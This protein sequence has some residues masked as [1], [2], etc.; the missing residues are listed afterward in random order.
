[1]FCAPASKGAG[2]GIPLKPVFTLRFPPIGAATK[3]VRANGSTPIWNTGGGGGVRV[4]GN[5]PKISRLLDVVA[6]VVLVAIVGAGAL[7]KISK[8]KASN[9]LGA[10]AAATV[11][12]PA[13]D[14]TSARLAILSAVVV[15]DGGSINILEAIMA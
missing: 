1:M 7:A 15:E 3:G 4:E 11:D 13:A 5:I 9:G 8:P 14:P 10:T 12:V 6:V 2:F